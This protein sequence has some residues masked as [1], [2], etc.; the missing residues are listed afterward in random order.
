MS[1]ALAMTWNPRGETERFLRFYP[2]FSRW[3]TGVAVITPPDPD[4]DAVEMLESLREVRVLTHGD[5]VAGRQLALDTA[6]EFDCDF[7]HYVDCDRLLRWF[8][9]HQDELC[10]TIDRAQTV[11]CL[12]IGRTEAAFAT[13][14]RCLRDTETITNEVFSHLLGQP[15]DLCAGSKAFSRTAAEFLARNSQPSHGWCTDAEWIVLLHRVG[16]SI[17]SVL[18]DG[19]DWETADR[20]LPHAADAD[21]QREAAEAYDTD[22][23]NWTA[24]VQVAHESIQ[25]GLAAMER[26]IEELS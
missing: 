23:L 14:P 11:D 1:I 2:E 24:R 19:L 13:H 16:F 25:A 3:Y 26:P 10:Q 20:Y 9:L 6:L 22:P 5:W 7:V 21:T 4:P 17:G 8:E 12:V 18:V 15:L